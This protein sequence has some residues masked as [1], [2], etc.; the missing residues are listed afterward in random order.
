MTKLKKNCLFWS[1]TLWS[2]G[3]ICLMFN[4]ML[5]HSLGG[6]V[7]CISLQHLILPY[8][9][10]CPACKPEVRGISIRAVSQ[11]GQNKVLL[12][13]KNYCP[14]SYKEKTNYPINCLIR[15]WLNTHSV[16]SGISNHFILYFYT[17]A[18]FKLPT[19]LWGT[20]LIKWKV[21]YLKFF[22]YGLLNKFFLRL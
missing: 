3:L 11:V 15:L 22:L 16:N 6:A 19:F 17:F 12:R 14:I 20:C 5:R 8:L 4:G 1:R 13:N 2:C 21:I 18:L 10:Y 7:I 9:T